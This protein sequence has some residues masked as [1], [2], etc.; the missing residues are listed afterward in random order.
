MKGG[1][2]ASC[3]LGLIYR[4]GKGGQE[5]EG[6]YKKMIFTPHTHT[7]KSIRKWEVGFLKFGIKWR[8]FG[9]SLSS[10]SCWGER[11]IRIGRV[12]WGRNFS[13]DGNCPTATGEINSKS[14]TIKANLPGVLG[15]GPVQCGFGPIQL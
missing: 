1:D 8:S 2:F 13:Q 12:R 4:N 9:I 5:K 10:R 15:S 7:H 14:Y 6:K 3:R 11:G